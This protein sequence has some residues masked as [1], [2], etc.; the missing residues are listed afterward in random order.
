M[1]DNISQK[2]ILTYDDI[3]AVTAGNSDPGEGFSNIPELC[4]NPENG[5]VMVAIDNKGAL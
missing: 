3:T 2:Q 1:Q 5:T 4:N